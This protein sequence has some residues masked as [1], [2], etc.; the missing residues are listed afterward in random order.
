MT[1]PIS[2]SFQRPDEG[3][4]T[5][6]NWVWRPR[7]STKL[8]SLMQTDRPA[9]RVSIRNVHKQSTSAVVIT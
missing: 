7:D 1:L 2:L 3:R 6:A 9:T 8:Q 4:A 5:L